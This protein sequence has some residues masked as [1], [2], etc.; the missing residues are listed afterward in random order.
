VLALAGRLVDRAAH[1]LAFQL[2]HAGIAISIAAD[3]TLLSALRR[4]PADG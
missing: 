4:E 2:S 1:D 3:P